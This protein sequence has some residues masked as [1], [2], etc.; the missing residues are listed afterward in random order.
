[1]DTKNLKFL[2]WT[3]HLS[4]QQHVLHNENTSGHKF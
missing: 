4:K 2:N 1:M 3:V